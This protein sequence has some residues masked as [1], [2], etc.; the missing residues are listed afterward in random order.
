MRVIL[1]RARYQIFDGHPFGRRFFETEELE[2]KSTIAT[3]CGTI[4]KSAFKLVMVKL[5][6]IEVF[7]VKIRTIS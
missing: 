7:K 3:T 1:S 5:S 2:F 6:A 4:L